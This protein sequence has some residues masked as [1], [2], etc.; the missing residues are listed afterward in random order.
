MKILVISDSHG[1]EDELI[2]VYKKYVGEIDHFM[3]CG[4]S[5]LPATHEALLGY[6]LVKGNCDFDT[7]IPNEAVLNIGGLHLYATHGHMYNVKMTMMNLSYRAEE[8]EANIVCFG[9]SHIA[10]CELINNK[11]FINPGS[12]RL[13]RGRKE[14]TYCILEIEDRNVTTNF[15]SHHH[16]KI[17][18]L[19]YN[20]NL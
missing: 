19:C 18:D 4:D 7:S 14:R 16:E 1:L 20:F 10:G 2:E 8:I 12:F 11:L 15:F 6:K 13:P 9:H 5:E 17:N 3:H